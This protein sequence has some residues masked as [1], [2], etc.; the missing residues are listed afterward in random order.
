[1]L[2][3]MPVCPFC[4]TDL[5]MPNLPCPACGKRMTDHPSLAEGKSYSVKPAGRTSGAMDAVRSRPAPAFA[6]QNEAPELEFSPRHA[7]K[8]RAGDG[9]SPNKAPSLPPLAAKKPSPARAPVV[10]APPAARASGSSGGAMAIPG[11]GGAVFEEDDIFGSGGGGAGPLELDTAGPPVASFQATSTPP[12]HAPGMQG[13]SGATPMGSGRPATPLSAGL[14][15]QPRVALSPH[16]LDAD[17]DEAAALADYGDTP[18]SWWQAPLYAYRVKTRQAEIRRQLAERQADLARARQ[19]EEEARIAFADHGR[20]A[21]ARVDV[22]AQ[23]LAAIAKAEEHMLARDGALAAEVQAHNA[24]LAVIDER[25]AGLSAELA[26]VKAEE[27]QIEEKLTDAEA[28]RQRADAKLKRAEI[29]IR[30]AQALV[31]SASTAGRDAA[32][33]AGLP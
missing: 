33:K 2:R 22:Y 27:R 18:E 4:Q 26:E 16:V 5:A 14:V 11:V 19:A 20:S 17:A 30:N 7:P 9:A 10:S 8:A 1:M 28:I 15:S 6:N 31:D 13:A 29:E 21:A 32:K 24:R 23:P 3:F 12:A 25:V